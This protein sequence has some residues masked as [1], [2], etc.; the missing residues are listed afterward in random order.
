[1]VLLFSTATASSCNL[2]MTLGVVLTLRD[3]YKGISLTTVIGRGSVCILGSP[4]QEHLPLVL[5]L[6]PNVCLIS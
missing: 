4:V 1:M 5:L 6:S 3:R 2:V